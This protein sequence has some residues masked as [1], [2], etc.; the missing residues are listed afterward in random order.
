MPKRKS[1]LPAQEQKEIDLI[2]NAKEEFHL[3]NRHLLNQLKEHPEKYRREE[4]KYIREFVNHVL[5]AIGNSMIGLLV[6]E[7]TT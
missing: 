2:R 6:T 4:F 1:Y 3:Q 7:V 5:I